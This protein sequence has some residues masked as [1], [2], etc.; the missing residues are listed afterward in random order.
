MSS[1]AMGRWKIA[2]YLSIYSFRLSFIW[3]LRSLAFEIHAQYFISA[4]IVGSVAFAAIYV[5]TLSHVQLEQAEADL[6][7]SEISQDFPS[8][9]NSLWM[10]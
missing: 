9:R 7:S 3:P 8:G 5:P 1:C 6:T 10:W 4:R 2:S